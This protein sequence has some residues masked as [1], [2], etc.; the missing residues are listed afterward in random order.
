MT[1]THFKVYTVQG[2]AQEFHRGDWAYNIG[3]HNG[4]LKLARQKATGPDFTRP[5]IEYGPMGWL[6][7]EQ[8][9]QD[10]RRTGVETLFEGEP[11]YN[12]GGE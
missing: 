8:R 12:L 2:A 6:C 1:Y 3:E 9:T 10:V 5:D 4:V 7:V 11:K